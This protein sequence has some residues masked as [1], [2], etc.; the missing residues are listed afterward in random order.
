MRKLDLCMI[1]A[2]NFSEL[3]N[4]DWNYL[5]LKFALFASKATPRASCCTFCLGTSTS[6]AALAEA[7]KQGLLMG[8]CQQKGFACL[9][10]RDVKHAKGVHRVAVVWHKAVHVSYASKNISKLQRSQE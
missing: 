4:D 5:M 9:H 7:D 1:C 10:L 2:C 8:P 6:A 3:D